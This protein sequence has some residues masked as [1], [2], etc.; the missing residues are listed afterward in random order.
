MI[1]VVDIERIE[2]WLPW[3]KKLCDA[4]TAL[5][6]RLPVE[7]RHADLLRMGL[8]D[9]FELEDPPKAI[10]KRLM[11]AGIV[12]HVNIKEAVYTLAQHSSGDCMY[13][14][15]ETRRC[16]IYDKRPETCRHHPVIGPRPGFC[17]HVHRDPT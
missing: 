15:R 11:K 17:P 6:C 16:T 12:A 14:N 7:V 10:A 1:K 2:T 13:L 9:A 4:C 8:I 3:R 5:C